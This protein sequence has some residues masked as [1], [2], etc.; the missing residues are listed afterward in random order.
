[1]SIGW[2]WMGFVNDDDDGFEGMSKLFEDDDDDDDKADWTSAGREASVDVEM[3]LG[4]GEARRVNIAV[5]ILDCLERLSSN[6]V[7]GGVVVS[8][9]TDVSA[10]SL[11]L[12][13][14][15][16]IVQVI[17]EN[18]LSNEMNGKRIS[19]NR[20]NGSPGTPMDRRCARN[21]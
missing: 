5:M 15:M 14:G 12:I 13:I 20:E 6:S 7:R 11:G 21:A 17:I 9:S 16:A 4:L 8:L 3:A 2:C 10:F 19:A 18:H 1:M